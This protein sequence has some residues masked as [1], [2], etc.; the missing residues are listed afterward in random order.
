MQQC[1]DGNAFGRIQKPEFLFDLFSAKIV[2]QAFVNVQRVCAK[3]AFP[4]VVVARGC[5]SGEEIA[6][7][8]REPFEQLI[9]ALALDIGII[10]VDK[11]FFIVN[12]VEFEVPLSYALAISS[13]LFISMPSSSI[14]I[15]NIFALLNLN[16]DNAPA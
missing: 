5:R 7:R 13:S 16:T 15:S 3:A 6:C 14:G 2:A 10:Y 1:H 8:A 4:S 9:R 11:F 12:N